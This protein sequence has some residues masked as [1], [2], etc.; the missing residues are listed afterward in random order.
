V[1]LLD[2]DGVGG[3]YPVQDAA[4]VSVVDLLPVA[5]CQLVREPR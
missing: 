3:K 4:D 5:V 1:A 2:H